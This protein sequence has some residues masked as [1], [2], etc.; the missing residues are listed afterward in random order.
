MDHD[1]KY[2]AFI[3]YKREDE[4]WA[5]WL[6][7]KLEHYKLPSSARKINPLLPE[8]V[9]PIFKD[10]TDLAGGVLEKTIQEALKASRYLIVVC[11]PRAAHSP[12]VSK[13]VQEFID[14]G[15]EECIIPFI[16]SGEPNANESEKECFPQNLRGLSGSRELLGIN[17]NEMGREAAA[18]KVVARMFGL[19][20][21][22]LWQRWERE[23]QKRRLWILLLSILAALI[24]ITIAGIMFY[25][26]RKMQ[27]NQ[28]RAVAYRAEQLVEQGNPYL[29][30][31]LLIKVLPNER[32][33][34]KW[35][36]TAEAEA[37]L[38][39]TE[40]DQSRLLIG[41]AYHLASTSFSS[42]GKFILSASHDHKV[43]V[44][45]VE[46]CEEVKT[47]NV[48]GIVDKAI[49]SPNG[50]QVIISH[51]LVN[52]ITGTIFSY[53]HIW[54]IESNTTHKIDSYSSLLS[55]NFSQDGK[56][57][58][59]GDG[60]GTIRIY[61]IN[62]L[63]C[64]GTLQGHSGS[65]NYVDFINGSQYLLSVS[66]DKTIRLWNLKA[67]T[68]VKTLT[69]DAEKIHSV[70]LS[71]DESSIVFATSDNNIYMWSIET[72]AYT[73]KFVGHT[74]KIHSLDIS[75]NGKYLVSASL[76]QTIKI[77][78]IDSMKNLKTFTEFE[79]AGSVSFSP[80]GEYIL[81]ADSPT[82]RM[83]E[84][85][86][87]VDL[88]EKI[89]ENYGDI[90]I[91]VKNLDGKS[92]F[93][94]ASDETIRMWE[95]PSGICIKEFKGHTDKIYNVLISEN[96]RQIISASNDMTIRVWDIKSGRCE[97][98]YEIPKGYKFEGISRDGIYFVFNDHGDIIFHNFESG[99][100]IEFN[101]DRSLD[102]SGYCSPDGKYVLT[103]DIDSSIFDNNIC[104]YEMSSG[105]CVKEFSGHT[106]EITSV[107]FTPDGEHIVSKS[108]WDRSI[109]IWDV[110]SG[111]CIKLFQNYN[112][113]TILY[114]NS[115]H[116]VLSLDK[117]VYFW[118]I[119]REKF[120]K[121]M[122]TDEYYFER[123]ELSKNGEYIIASC[124]DGCIRLWDLQHSACIKTFYPKEG[125]M[126]AATFIDNDRYILI[127]D[128][129]TK[130]F[131]QFHPMQE[132][133]EM[134]CERFENN[135]LTDKERREYYLE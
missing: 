58:V 15:R 65:V 75:P 110:T 22:T 16:V 8:R 23:T 100:T 129:Y 127:V 40:M 74:N 91:I 118:D 48:Q 59:V 113:C 88:I 30:Q 130:Y 34:F 54:D 53:L 70:H 55:M 79:S 112:P 108:I 50:K 26:H 92:F 60:D 101:G 98:V 35:P 109:R 14:S 7:H 44:W 24:G 126:A 11:S 27:I 42:D 81:F 120:V 107:Y 32:D 89:D 104:L 99:K 18:I 38:R 82:I 29:A 17:I 105:K 46:T 68:C 103:I 86:K 5:K 76:D 106:G 12:W 78:D 20:F 133:M 122:M 43:I 95:V 56:L 72:D 71:P 47:C 94:V 102:S 31:K 77:W 1:Y 85:K 117:G 132:L 63:V 131:W 135:P 45:D 121:K 28:A 97:N 93:T 52:H 39:A 4:K 51:F 6:Q 10:T 73:K 124:S 2:L 84:I 111:K 57:L 36:Y 67:E 25:Q 64:V 123:A 115:R 62:L 21:D 66:S 49:F 134:T 69:V 19:Q 128:G 125:R 83:I 9:K 41:H 3:S 96:G 116:L 119:K 80:D 90:R 37:A 13:E 87:H 61:D 33:L 114:L